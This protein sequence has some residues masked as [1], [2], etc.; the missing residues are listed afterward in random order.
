M[1]AVINIS[2]PQ[3]MAELIDNVVASGK[4][5]TKSEF[6]RHLLREWMENHEVAEIQKGR[7]ELKLGKGKVLHTL[8]E[9]R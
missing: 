5:A 3:S 9:L 2:L 6:F 8:K 1:R 4:Y 7:Q